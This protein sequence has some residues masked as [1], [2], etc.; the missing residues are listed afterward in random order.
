M[1]QSKT[2]TWKNIVDRTK[3]IVEDFSKS[4]SSTNTTTTTFEIET[5]GNNI[6][7][8]GDRLIDEA[9]KE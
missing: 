4:H 3:S 1:Y 5:C 9:F 6:D 2:I 8:D 7:D